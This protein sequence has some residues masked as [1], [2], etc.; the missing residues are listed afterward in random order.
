LIGYDESLAIS[1]SPAIDHPIPR[2]PFSAEESYTSASSGPIP[3]VPGGSLRGYRY[4]NEPEGETS[5][6]NAPMVLMRIDR[7]VP[8]IHTIFFIS[9]FLL[10]YFFE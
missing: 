6:E 8:A 4:V 10:S 3:F 1:E 5:W 9:N 2:I 7:M